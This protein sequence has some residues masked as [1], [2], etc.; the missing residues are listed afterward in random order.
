[1]RRHLVLLLALT[2]CKYLDQPKKVAELEKRLDEVSG[3]LTEMTGEPVGQRPSAKKPDA[4]D[5]EGGHGKKGKKGGKDAK[6]DAKDTKKDAKAGKA[7]ADRDA[8]E[9]GDAKDDGD[10]KATRWRK[11]D[12]DREDAAAEPDEDAAAAADAAADDRHPATNDAAPAVEPAAAANV[13]WG[14][15]GPDGPA[16]WAKLDPSFGTCARGKLQSPI[17]IMPRRSEAPEVIFVYRPTAAAIVDTGHTIEV[18]LDPGSFIVVD[19]TRFDLIQFHF[20]TPA[21]HTLAG[22]SFPMELHLVHRS[23]AGKLAVIG[24]LYTE[25]ES[26]VALAPVWKG[27]P[28]AKGTSKLKKAFDPMALLPKD[29]A[30][31]RYDGSLTTPPCS[32]GVIWHVLKRPRTEDDHTIELLR[33]R[34]GANA[35]P[36]QELGD[37]ELR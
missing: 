4:E 31:Y 17:D 5:D 1:M 32:E 9:D 37:R 33:R 30:A 27:A 10:D 26:S 29:Q 6:K 2:G 16:S 12:R 22:D 13:H 36:V 25:G 3:A 7:K 14:Y 23:K 11:A 21:E 20:H 28:R 24:V 18:D 19:G 8:K 35:R 15:T 34:F